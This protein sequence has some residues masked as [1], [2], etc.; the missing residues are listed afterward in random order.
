MVSCAGASESIFRRSPGELAYSRTLALP[1]EP[2]A[3]PHTPSGQRFDTL[4]DAAANAAKI[5]DELGQD[6][7]QYR[8]S[9]VSVKPMKNN[10]NNELMRVPVKA[11]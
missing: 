1:G 6:G 9:T 5:A 10:N 7:D 3:Q 2:P 11:T 8:G 4:E